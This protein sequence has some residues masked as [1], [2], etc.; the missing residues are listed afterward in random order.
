MLICLLFY[1]EH[2]FHIEGK[3]KIIPAFTYCTMNIIT[4]GYFV[5]TFSANY[6]KKDNAIIGALS[7]VILVVLLI[8]VYVIIQKNIYDNM[9]LMITA[10]QLGFAKIGYIIMYLAVFTTITGCL[11]VASKNNIVVCLGVLSISFVV[12]L[13]G[14]K[15]IVDIFYPIMGIVGAITS[16]ICLIK[17][18]FDRKKLFKNILK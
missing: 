10:R 7:G 13:L 1:Y 3:I 12:S 9:P 11:S 2:N 8:L 4:G 5:S 6:T 18:T 17:A 16:I 15:K 14:F